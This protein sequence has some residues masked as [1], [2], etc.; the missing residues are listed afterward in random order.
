[1]SDQVYNETEK[2]EEK[3]GQDVLDAVWWAAVLIW[4][5]LVLLAEYLGLLTSL[6]PLEAWEVI[7]IGAGVLALLGAVI[8]L[9]V[10]AY[11]HRIGWA[12]VV[13]VVL[14]A[15]GVGS[16]VGWGVI[17]P[18]VLI[19]IGVVVLVRTVVLRQQ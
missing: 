5:G 4:V 1:M 18:V 2:M 12:I 9:L 19:G 14:I 6:W 15:I 10:P 7:F 3:L 16:T 13:G 17:G 8:R 11:R